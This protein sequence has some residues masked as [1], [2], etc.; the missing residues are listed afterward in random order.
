MIGSEGWDPR[1]DESSK[2]PCQDRALH[3][4]GA[5]KTFHLS[6]CTSLYRKVDIFIVRHFSIIF[7]IGFVP[8]VSKTLLSSLF[9]NIFPPIFFWLKINIFFKCLESFNFLCQIVF[10]SVMGW[11][12]WIF[13]KQEKNDISGFFSS[14]RSRII[15]FHNFLVTSR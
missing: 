14:F 12:K 13:W 8:S 15:N 11:K 4:P 5:Q 1:Q 9:I 3:G 10:K 6:Y 2:A 7:D